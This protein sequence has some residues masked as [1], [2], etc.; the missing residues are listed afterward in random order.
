MKPI[1]RQARALDD[2]KQEGNKPDLTVVAT[3]SSTVN[4]PNTDSRD[5]KQE[6]TKNESSLLKQ[7]EEFGE[8]DYYYQCDRCMKRMP[9]LKLVLQHRKLIH[10]VK[11]TGP[12]KIKDIDT[13]PDIH[14]PNFHCKSCNIDYNSRRKYRHHLKYV[15]FMALKTISPHQIPQSS[16][17]PD[18]DDPNLYCRACDSKYSCKSNYKQHCR[19]A[20]GMTS[21]KI[22]NTGANS[23]GITDTYCELCDVRLASK[24]SYKSHLFSIHKVDWRLNQQKSKNIT[25]D[26]ND[27][28]FYCCA[29]EIKLA[30]KETFRIHLMGVHAIY[31]TAPKK[32]SLEPDIND[33]NNNCRTCQ[34]SY[35]LRSKY[36]THLRLVHQIVLPPL[37]GSADPGK[38]PDPNDPQNYCNVYHHSISNRNAMIDIN[39]PEFYCA[40]CERS[41]SCKTQFVAHIRNVH[42]I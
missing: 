41:Y 17:V 42:N 12:S 20:H 40:Q 26:I 1:H 30:T 39:H 24:S 25:P 28:N 37:I 32:T 34:K 6:D 13:E 15:H 4:E 27:P 38:L 16:I 14:D 33:P 29:C 23:D 9:N 19:Y 3:S 36:R 31:R 2:F 5:I 11:R 18:P 10:N 35:S 21:V 7:G 8:E 22:A